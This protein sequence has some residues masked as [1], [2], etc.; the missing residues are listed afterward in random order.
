MLPTSLRAQLERTWR[1][2]GAG[3]ERGVVRT[4]SFS[5]RAPL[6]H[7]VDQMFAGWASDLNIDI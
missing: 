6:P 1:G 2:G 3:S 4:R 7:F 5:E